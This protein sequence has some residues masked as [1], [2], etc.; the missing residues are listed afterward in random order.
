MSIGGALKIAFSPLVGTAIFYGIV[1]AMALI[2]MLV[3]EREP[4]S[5]AIAYAL[6]YLAWAMSLKLILGAVFDVFVGQF[7]GV[8][9]RGTMLLLAT[10]LAIGG[11]ILLMP[12][13]SEYAN[14]ARF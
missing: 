1:F 2:S 3:I 12:F 9:L 10:I 5:Q 8:L 11:M 6:G 14:R 7:D 13:L 4:L